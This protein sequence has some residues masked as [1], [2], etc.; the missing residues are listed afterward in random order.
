MFNRSRERKKYLLRSPKCICE[1]DTEFGQE[2]S[3]NLVCVERDRS[4]D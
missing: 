1:D 2:W 3:F 4:V